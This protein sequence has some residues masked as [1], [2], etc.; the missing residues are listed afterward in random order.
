MF[1]VRP[2]YRYPKTSYVFFSL[3]VVGGG[4]G[5]GG[6]DGMKLRT[7]ISLFII[8]FID[9]I[10]ITMFKTYCF[11]KIARIIKSS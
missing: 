5:G 7:P 1:Y 3:C 2:N 10:K 6:G 8:S 11:L 4:G 9:F